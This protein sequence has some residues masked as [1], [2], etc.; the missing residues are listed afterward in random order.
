[1]AV[2]LADTCSARLFVFDM[3]EVIRK[4][5]VAGTRTN[6]TSVGGWSQARYQRHVDNFHQQHAKEVVEV[7]EGMVAEEEID[8]IVLAGDE[9]IMPLLREQMPAHLTEM[10]IDVLRLDMKTP[11]NEVLAASLDALRKEDAKNDVEKAGHL[12]DEFRSGNL[13]VAGVRET[14][15]ALKN[16]QVDELILSASRKDIREGEE[17]EEPT[18][19]EDE[20]HA[21]ADALVSRAHQTAAKVTFIE[22]PALLA[23]IGGVG[24]LLRYRL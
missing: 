15:T 12:L 7:L 23:D 14:L 19:G 20:P 18:E 11:E 9:V 10:V 21:V 3:G 13:G 5:N 8:K 4:R 22:D 6:R 17:S 24:A 1:Y 2:V 16:G